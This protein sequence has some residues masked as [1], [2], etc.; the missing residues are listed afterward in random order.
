LNPGAAG[1]YPWRR[2]SPRRGGIAPNG[3]L[4]EEED[5]QGRL[6]SP[7]DQQAEITKLK[8]GTHGGAA[9]DTA[10]RSANSPLRGPSFSPINARRPIKELAAKIEQIQSTRKLLK[11]SKRGGLLVRYGEAEKARDALARLVAIR[12]HFLAMGLSLQAQDAISEN[13]QEQAKALYNRALAAL[14]NSQ[15]K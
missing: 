4:A 5:F 1:V 3:S 10:T 15:A 6:G 12:A 8:D 7:S 2:R 14:P 9:A 11:S 13:F